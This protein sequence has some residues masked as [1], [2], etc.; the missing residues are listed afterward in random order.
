MIPDRAPPDSPPPARVLVVD[1]NPDVAG[2]VRLAV[3]KIER[4]IEVASEVNPARALERLRSERFDLVLGD[5]RMR[6][7]D[8]LEFLSRAR[9]TQPE[10]RRVLFTAH[11]GK[12]DPGALE[13]SHVDGVLEKPTSLPELRELLDAILAGDRATLAALKR[14]VEARSSPSRP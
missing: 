12:L 5:F 4:R 3:R 14:G 8:G 11:A 2:I 10:G 13:R 1:D 7:M 6:E 9:E